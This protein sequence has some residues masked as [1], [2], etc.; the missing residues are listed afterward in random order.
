MIIALVLVASNY[1]R[2]RHQRCRE[3]VTEVYYSD[4]VAK[5]I[6]NLHDGRK[7]TASGVYD[8]VIDEQSGRLQS[9]L[10]EKRSLFGLRGGG[11]LLIPWSAV[12][13]VGDDV[14]ILDQPIGSNNSF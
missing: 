7:L 3:G 2:W 9:L 13:R 11:E 6:V 5:E 12:K 4:L 14:I 8:I 1:S 10:V